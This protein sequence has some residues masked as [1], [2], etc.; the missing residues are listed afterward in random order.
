MR[1]FSSNRMLVEEYCL[2]TLSPW[3]KLHALSEKLRV[4]LIALGFLNVC[5][6]LQHFVCFVWLWVCW[7]LC[8]QTYLN[9]IFHVFLSHIYHMFHT[10]LNHHLKKNKWKFKK[11]TSESCCSVTIFHKKIPSFSPECVRMFD[12]Y[13]RSKTC[14]CWQWLL[15]HTPATN[16]AKEKWK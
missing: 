9:Q 3:S 7:L 6:L 10:Y 5:H 4:N 11:I 15:P 1:I 14:N 2:E 12:L 16:E 13:A 8:S